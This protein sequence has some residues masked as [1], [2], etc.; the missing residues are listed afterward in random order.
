[1]KKIRVIV[2]SAVIATILMANYLTMVASEEES[3]PEP[4]YRVEKIEAVTWEEDEEA[5]TT[6]FRKT[7]LKERLRTITESEVKE[8]VSRFVDVDNHWGRDCIGKLAL[9]EIVAGYGNGNFGP[10]DT[11]KVDEFIKMTLRSMGYKVE[12]GTGYWAEPYIK[13]AKEEN[14]IEENEF[15]DYRRPIRREEAARI[16]VKAVL[17]EEEAPIPNHTSY[18]K[19]RIPDYE[20]I[21]DNYKQHVLYSYSLGLITGVG[22]GV[23]MPKKNLTRAEGSTIIIRAI[24][25]NSRIPMKPEDSETVTVWNNLYKR[26]YVIYPPLKPEIIDVIRVMKIAATKSKVSALMHFNIENSMVGVAFYNNEEDYQKGTIFKSGSFSISLADWDLNRGSGYE[27]AIFE[28]DKVKELHREAYVELFNYLFEKDADRAIKEFDYYLDIKDG[29]E[30]KK[31]MKFNGRRT[32][33][34]KFQG[35]KGFGMG[36]AVK[37]N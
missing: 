31:E 30:L 2:I 3:V 17:K 29:R 12:E 25:E 20:E 13:L 36:I 14:L 5:T 23:F 18:A 22:N 6:G 8:T 37:D 4:G 11:L 32:I 10:E 19:R 33:F 27:I 15:S 34:A 16:V 26:E 35:E 7:P 9:L 21:G 1:M 28:P 24:D